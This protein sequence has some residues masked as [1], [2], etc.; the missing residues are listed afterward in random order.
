M[1]LFDIFKRKQKVEKRDNNPEIEV[2]YVGQPA[3]KYAAITDVTQAMQNSIVYRGV[4]I[5]SDSV[6]SIPLLIYRK[7]KNGY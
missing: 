2:R 6:A 3:R 4:S 5:L 7:D 1:A